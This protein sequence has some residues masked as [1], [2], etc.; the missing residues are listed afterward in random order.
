MFENKR[1]AILGLGKSGVAAAKELSAR[2]AD[3]LVSDSRSADVLQEAI[4]SLGD[5]RCTIETGGHS[6]A[7]LERDILVVSPGVPVHSQLVQTALARGI[8][9]L[10]EVEVAWRL[11]PAP[12]IAV[13]GTNGKSTTVTLIKRMLG[14]RAVLAG[15]IGNPLVAEV[16]KA[17]VGGFVVAEVSNFQL[18]TVAEFRPRIAVLTNITPDH[19]D[20]HPS[21]AEYFAA[22]ARLFAQQREDD[23]AIFCQDDPEAVRMETL[24]RQGQLPS[25]LEGFAAP[26]VPACP[27]VMTYSTVGPV[28]RGTCFRDGWIYLC[29]GASEKR[30]LRWDFPGLPGRHNLANGLAAVLVACHLNV[31]VDDMQAAL[32]EHHPLHYRMELVRTLNGVRFVNDSKGTN[33]D[34]VVA[35]LA[36]YSEPVHLIAGGKDKGSDFS[37]LVAAIKKHC[38]QTLLIGEAADRLER[39]LRTIGY[40]NICR[41][42]SLQDAVNYAWKSAQTGEVVLL[43]PACSSFD[44]FHSAEERGALFAQYAMKVE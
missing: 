31:S 10:G 1:V 7:V 28:E 30:V 18:E 22:K 11:S 34:S 14:E 35:A 2:G 13:T 38:R 25:W 8:K 40:E 17:P 33:P 20:R 15:N 26:R 44:M 39:E 36:T 3:V 21:Y 32:S 23:L 27:A 19:L 12:F 4:A 42:S 43:S 9:V 16:A 41:C 5:T 29:D 6:D 37:S 24:L